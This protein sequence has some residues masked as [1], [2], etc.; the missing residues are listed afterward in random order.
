MKDLF[1]LAGPTAVGKT[2]ISIKLAKKL[3]GEIISADSMQIYKYM[4]IGSAKITKSEM[5]GINHHM[6]DIVEPD[7]SFNVSKYK[8]I[9]LNCI[10]KIYNNKKLPMLVGGTGLY[11]NSLIF[12]YNF[13]EAKV[14]ENY[15]K[16]LECLANEKGKD[17]VH[18]LLKEVDGDSY[19][20]LYP[21]D[22][23]RVIRALEVYKLT[24]KPIGK[25]NK[26]TNQYD[27]PFKIYYF[28]LN[29]DRDKL[30]EKINR[31]VDIMM[32]NGLIDEVKK[33]KS[34]GYDMSIQSMKGIGYKEILNYLDGKMSLDSTVDLIKKNSRHYAKRQL[35]WFRKDTRVNWVN[36]DEFKNDDAVIDY[37]IN[38]FATI[39]NL[40]KS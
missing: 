19:E 17:Y 7:E 4:D 31:R 34:M 30:Y 23:K 5:C 24:G 25:F 16:H 36:K 33:L 6:I 13:T 20:K 22:L 10:Q 1:I 38:K 3:N 15:R 29:M 32:S 40:Y 37:I 27:I 26:N 35:T 21:N 14:D 11:I 8:N 12:N 28:V 18:S 2:D 9:A 39:S